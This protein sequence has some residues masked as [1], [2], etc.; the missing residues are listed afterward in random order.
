MQRSPAAS[1]DRARNV[2]QPSKQ[3]KNAPQRHAE[4]SNTHSTYAALSSP[5]SFI[6]LATYNFTVVVLRIAM[7]ALNIAVHISWLSQCIGLVGSRGL[8]PAIHLKRISTGIFAYTAPTDSMLRLVCCI[9]ACSGAFMAFDWW[10][11]PSWLAMAVCLLTYTSL[12]AC[13]GRFMGLQM[14]AKVLELNFW[15]ALMAF[16]QNAHAW[17]L[18]AQ[19]FTVRLMVGG[20]LGKVT[21]GDRSWLNLTAMSWHYWTM[22]LPN[23]LSPYF[24]RL[25]I[26]VHKIE[27]VITLVVEGPLG[28][29]AIAPFSALRTLA[30]LGNVGLLSG[31]N[32]SGNFGH[33]WLASFCGAL[34][35]LDDSVWQIVFPEI[36]NLA[37]VPADGGVMSLRWYLGYPILAYYAAVQL[38][39][40]RHTIRSGGP[41]WIHKYI[42]AP[43]DKYFPEGLW[44][45][46]QTQYLQLERRS[47]MGSY[48]KFANMT[49]FRNELVLEAQDEKGQWV[50][51]PF[52]YKPSNV[53]RPLPFVP[54]C[55]LPSLDWFLWFIPLQLDRSCATVPEWFTRL[56]FAVAAQEPSVMRLLAAD[57]PF[58]SQ[59]R[60]QRVR[61][62]LYPYTYAPHA[63]G[64]PH[65]WRR[66]DL[67]AVVAD[68]NK[69]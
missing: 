44:A 65:S 31:I 63:N 2:T 23:R 60:P 64:G 5:V 57:Q 53:D 67:I 24:Y 40:F 43:F 4:Q 16:T 25:P 12:R 56:M 33:L 13:A 54:I 66:G 62:K 46:L 22:P 26:W 27:G 30:C 28:I 55:H 18:L 9:G 34:A 10:F 69:Q 50:E 3:K 45:Q 36:V 15:Y 11:F 39:P 52:K 32:L 48:V 17:A 41:R 7:A 35:S 38:V 19:V 58:N 47:L 59:K 1:V 61:A 6:M 8:A 14:H 42:A 51:I 68:T 37:P 29:L 49:K 20:G 21:G